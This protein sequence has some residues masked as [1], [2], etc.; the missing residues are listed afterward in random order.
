MPSA[1]KLHYAMKGNPMPALVVMFQL[2]AY[3][4]SASA[5]P[6]AFLGHPPCIELLV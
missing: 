1:V 2:G 6:H 4:A 5:S 3:G